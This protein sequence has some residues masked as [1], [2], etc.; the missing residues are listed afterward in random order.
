MYTL[1]TGLSGPTANIAVNKNRIKHYA[2]RVY[3]K[4]GTHFEI[5]LFNPKS[6]KVLAKIYLDGKS[7]S[8]TGIVIKPGQR[9][10]LERWIDEAK[11]FLYETYEVD[12]C[13][14]QAIIGNGKVRVQFFD[15]S[16]ASLNMPCYTGYANY[17]YDHN[18]IIGATMPLS[19]AGSTVSNTFTTTTSSPISTTFTT[20][21]SANGYSAK[22]ETGRTEVGESSNQSFSHD[23]S[24]YSSWSCATVD[25][26]ILPDGNRPVE[27]HEIRN[28][29]TDCGTRHKKASWKFC[30][31]CGTK[32]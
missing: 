13:Y 5:E 9:I 22:L 30:P 10:F 1:F 18:Q 26:Q 31:N 16:S 15:E 6:T 11:K 32:I 7:I 25:I 20:S 12:Q 24:Q 27:S 28:Y 14:N 19:Y 17:P 23:S 4:D 8:S 2:E 21:T 3:L 29:C